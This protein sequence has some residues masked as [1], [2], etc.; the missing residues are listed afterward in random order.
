MTKTGQN[1]PPDFRGRVLLG[2]WTLKAPLM[3][4][5]QAWKSGVVPRI[6]NSSVCI[7]PLFVLRYSVRHSDSSTSR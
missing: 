7:P 5:V 3:M 4:S 6:A 1:P 2:R